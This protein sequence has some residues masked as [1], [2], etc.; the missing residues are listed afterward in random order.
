M[1]ALTSY[2]E[3][4]MERADYEKLSDG[5]YGGEIPELDG[6]IAFGSTSRQCEQEPRSTLED[7]ILLAFHLGHTLP[8]LDGIDLNKPH[9]APV[10]SVPTT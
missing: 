6:I 2:I 4:A 5:T 10:E 1:L 3:A 9:Y 7:W 8:I